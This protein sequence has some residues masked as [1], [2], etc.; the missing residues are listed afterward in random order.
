MI[1]VLI[2]ADVDDG[3]DGNTDAESY[4]SPPAIEAAVEAACTVAGF[5]AGRPQLCVRFS[6]D[7]EIRALNRQWRDKDRVTDVLSFPMQESPVD[8]SESLG[9]IALAVPFVRREAA[10]LGLPVGAHTLHLI[11]HATLHLL[12]FDHVSDDEAEQMQQLER[13]AMRRIGLHDPYPQEHVH[14]VKP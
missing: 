12:G 11:I 7:A 6:T 5:T 4:V 9:D 2:D 8:L 13:T 3:I 10:R 1:D 14:Q